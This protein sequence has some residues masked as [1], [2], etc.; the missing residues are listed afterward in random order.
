MKQTLRQAFSDTRACIKETTALLGRNAA[1]V[2]ALCAL[3]Y[4]LPTLLAQITTWQVTSPI[5]AQWETFVRALIAGEADAQGMSDL[6]LG[7]IEGMSEATMRTG[8][9]SLLVSFFLAPSLYAACA[10]LNLAQLRDHTRLSANDAA[11][12][13]IA[14]WKSLLFLALIITLLKE[15]LSMLPYVAATALSFIS[16]LLAMIPG[17]S[18]VATII[19]LVLV[20][21]VQW[22][23]NFVV[24]I[25]LSFVW[26]A[27]M[28]EDKR[29]MAALGR[30]VEVFKR[31]FGVAILANL[32]LTL[33]AFAI[34]AVVMV[35]WTV[36]F[37]AWGAPIRI[38]QLADPIVQSLFVPIECAL[39]AV[40]FVRA[41]GQNAA[42][43]NRFDAPEQIDSFKS[44]N[45][46][47]ERA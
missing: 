3:L 18:G 25:A 5:F 31:C 35:L 23:F 30:S 12:K 6:L 41:G 4:L 22:A 2:F 16:G 26:P 8:L 21:L 44:A 43:T 1:S 45:G 24:A 20:M 42:Q 47:D 39:C 46:P 9:V 11:Y 19:G 37:F 13:T 27:I 7:T 33:V 17:L 40:L 32:A 28:G 10:Y 14:K 29:G 34:S 38:M 15:L 36:A